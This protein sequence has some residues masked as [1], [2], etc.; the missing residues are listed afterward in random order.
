M[1][2][3][4]EPC[5]FDLRQDPAEE[6]N[7]ASLNPA[8][9]T[10]LMAR[11]TAFNVPQANASIDPAVLARDYDCVTDIRPWWGNFSGPCCKRKAVSSV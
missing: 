5:L 6:V 9:V 7:I 4:K 2:T 10:D 1:C 11:L 8:I 3:R